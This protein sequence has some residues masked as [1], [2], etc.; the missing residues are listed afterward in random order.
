MVLV[1]VAV[2]AVSGCVAV[3]PHPVPESEPRPG[4]SSGVLGPG[5]AEPQF[6]QSPADEALEEAVSARSPRPATR[7]SPEVHRSTPDRTPGTVRA[8]ATPPPKDR[9]GERPAER[10]SLRLPTASAAITEVCALGETYGD[11]PAG[12]LQ[13]RICREAHRN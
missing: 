11:W 3:E 9:P 12:S 7:P 4:A 1:G 8:S 10:W 13:D 5:A 6:G 2:T